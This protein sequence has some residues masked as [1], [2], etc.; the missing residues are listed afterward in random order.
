MFC[1]IS[2]AAAL[3]V[4]CLA[5]TSSAQWQL[6]PLYDETPS[7]WSSWSGESSSTQGYGWRPY[8]PYPGQPGNPYSGTTTPQSVQPL[9]QPQAPLSLPDIQYAP[10]LPQSFDSGITSSEYVPAE[11]QSSIPVET[12]QSN[13]LGREVIINE[14]PVDGKI[15]GVVQEDGSLLSLEQFNANA[16]ASAIAK[17]QSTSTPEPMTGVGDNFGEPIVKPGESNDIVVLES[18][19]EPTKPEPPS[20][21]LASELE[22]PSEETDPGNLASNSDLVAPSMTPDEA[23]EKRLKEEASNEEAASKVANYETR[24]A[25][26]AD[27]I[28]EAETRLKEQDKELATLKAKARQQER[29]MELQTRKVKTLTKSVNDAMSKRKNSDG[30]ELAA[31]KKENKSLTTKLKSMAANSIQQSDS[32]AEVSKL[33]KKLVQTNRDMVELRREIDNAATLEAG[34]RERE[35]KLKER[36]KTLTKSAEEA[37]SKQKKSGSRELAALKKENRSLTTKLESMAANSVQQSDSAA[38]ASKLRKKLVQ[39]N[40]DMVELRREIDEANDKVQRLEIRNKSRLA[41]TVKLKGELSDSKEA[42]GV[43][44]TA[45]AAMKKKMGDMSLSKEKSSKDA[46]SMKRLEKSLARSK[47]ENAATKEKLQESTKLLGKTKSKLAA[48][49]KK[50]SQLKSKF[51]EAFEAEKGKSAG[52]KT[53]ESEKSM[54]EAEVREQWKKKRDKEERKAREMKKE[55]EKEKKKAKSKKDDNEKK[56][57]KKKSEKER[58]LERQKKDLIEEMKKKMAESAARIRGVGKKKIDALIK[59]GKKEDS[60]EVKKAQERIDESVKIANRKIRARYERR[61]KRLK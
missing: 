57:A 25:Q 43:L 44:E 49:E 46:E 31:L 54:T 61:L 41:S 6:T 32:A 45:M 30:S 29:V 36:L 5:Q 58:K 1:R 21:E 15:L 7:N 19:A 12:Q 11:P 26:M 22:P 52:K 47:K 35:Q 51:M 53:R 18:V 34:N 3:A 50:Y 14:E 24:I 16:R 27:V 2:C 10:P 8:V 17:N 48:Q 4:F 20:E 59:D 9:S 40:R 42:N 33:R 55:K 39:T 28:K 37:V 13:N 38:E 56:E 23:V 60:D